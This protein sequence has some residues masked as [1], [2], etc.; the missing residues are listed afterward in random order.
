MLQF[1]SIVTITPSR[2]PQNT[3]PSEPGA[4]EV[5]IT[6]AFH[7]LYPLQT[8]LYGGELPGKARC[9]RPVCKSFIQCTG[10]IFHGNSKM[11]VFQNDQDI[12]A[13]F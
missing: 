9:S 4:C 12:N 1:E 6:L 10:K 13:L 5:E 3:Q 2:V 8:C 11:I 7:D